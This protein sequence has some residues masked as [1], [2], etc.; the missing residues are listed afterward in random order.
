MTFDVL[1]Y[2]NKFLNKQTNKKAAV[3]LEN[4]LDGDTHVTVSIEVE[5]K[6]SERK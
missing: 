1:V 2:K 5:P 3:F 6:Q 4:K